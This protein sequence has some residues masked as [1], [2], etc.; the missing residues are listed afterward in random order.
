MRAYPATAPEVARA[1]TGHVTERDEAK[2]DWVVYDNSD[3]DPVLVD[4]GK[5]R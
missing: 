4:R 3:E 1:I 5:N 2:H